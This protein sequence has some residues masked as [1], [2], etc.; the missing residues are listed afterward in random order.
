MKK[1]A[2]GELKGTFPCRIT[3]IKANILQ[4]YSPTLR[5]LLSPPT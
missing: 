3:E 5:T 1:A 4:A 2:E